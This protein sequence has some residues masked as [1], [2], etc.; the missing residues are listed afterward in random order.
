MLDTFRDRGRAPTGS[1]RQ[2][3]QNGAGK[4]IRRWASPG[5]IARGVDKNPDLLSFSL[6]RDTTGLAV[7]RRHRAPPWRRHTMRHPN[8]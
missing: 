2:G 3:W 8:G 1:L 7:S 4:S 6:A 5:R